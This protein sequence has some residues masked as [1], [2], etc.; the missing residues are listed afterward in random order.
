LGRIVELRHLRYFVVVAEERHFG[1][2]ADRLHLAQPPLSRQIRALETELGVELFHRTTRRVDLT[3]AGELLLERA[4]SILT[5]VDSATE[6]CR[7]AARGEAGRLSMGFTGSTTYGLLPVVAGALRERLPGVELELHG[8]MLTPAQIRGLMDET[9]D[10]A[11][12]RPPVR[13]RAVKLEVIRSES[14]IAALESG[15]RLAEL[16]EIPLGELAEEPFITYPSHFRS[17]VHDAVEEACA[18]AGF[19]PRV[20][21]EAAET[22][23]LVSFVAAG[24]GVALVPASVAAMALPG[25]TYRPLAGLAPRVELAVAWRR[26]DDSPV[27]G[28]ALAVVHEAITAAA[29]TQEV[30]TKT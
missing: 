30:A 28:R 11:L 5:A 24:V 13:E 23:T 7:R 18:A 14:L 10:I 16:D 17:V 2:A 19:L 4:R 1:R 21:M 8:E 9:L 3:P 25:I 22:A 6:D 26:E 12:L 27:V 29:N 15:H 20:R